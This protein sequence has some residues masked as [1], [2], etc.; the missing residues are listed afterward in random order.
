MRIFAVSDIH[1]D[2]PANARW[3]FGLSRADYTDDVLLLA[4][5][6]SD[7]PGLL[8]RCFREL[9]ARFK[10]VLYVPGN[11]DLWVIRW[12]KTKNSLDKFRFIEAMAHDQGISMQPW[13]EGPLS[14]V[15]LLSWYDYS[16]GTP[17]AELHGTWMD[18][19]ACAW[20]AGFA[21]LDVTRH[22]LA[23][24]EAALWTRNARIVSFS[25]FLPRLDL[26]PSYIPPTRRV[27]YPVLGTSR[28]DGQIRELGSTIHVY[29]HSHVNRRVR[30]DGVEYVNNAFGYPS[31]T[32]IA[33]K[34]L[35]SIL[36]L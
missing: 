7:D 6:V 29:G 5:D 11:H 12:D 25:H 1:I 8:E 21:P 4:G 36:E 30:I 16:F 24:N 18:Y 3:L 22:F 13:H 9:G 35:I 32:H 20:P 15:P 19:R 23:R 34:A 10:K 31:E 27:L 26:M 2:Y 17:D 28:L 14:I 33:E